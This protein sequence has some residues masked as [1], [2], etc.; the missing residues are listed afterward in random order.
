[1]VRGGSRGVRAGAATERPG[2][3]TPRFFAFGAELLRLRRVQG[4]VRP[5]A[6]GVRKVLG[7]GRGRRGAAGL[8]RQ[9][10][11]DPLVDRRR[12]EGRGLAPSLVNVALQPLFGAEYVF[13]AV[14]ER[15]QAADRGGRTGRTR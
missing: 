8:F 2:A 7:P 6:E 3:A 12:V 13:E 1:M 9:F 10:F 11:L 14:G 5:G 15:H 4:S